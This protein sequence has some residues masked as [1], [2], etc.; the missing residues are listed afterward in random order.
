ML[1]LVVRGL[2]VFIL[3][4]VCVLFEGSVGKH[5]NNIVQF[6]LKHTADHFY[7]VYNR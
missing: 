7:S 4:S 5:I 3:A 6:V 2:G 1:L